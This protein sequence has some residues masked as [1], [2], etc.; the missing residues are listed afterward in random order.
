VSASLLG[1]VAGA[2]LTGHR[3]SQAAVRGAAAGAAFLGAAEAVSRARQRPG[4]IPELWSRILASGALAAPVGWAGGRLSRAR[5]LTV[6][7]VSGAVAGA[8]GLRPQK[9][10]LG[11]A[12]GAA[13]GGAFELRDRAAEPAVV[14]AT[15]VVA[16][17][18]L[19]A[20]LFRDPQV[21]MLAERVHAEDLPFVV[22]LESRSWYVGT[23]YVRQL[24][25]VLGGT[26]TADAADVGIVAALESLAGPEFDPAQ[27]DPL[28]REFYEHT[29]RFL[30]DI[31]PEWRLWVRPGYLLYRNLFAR[32]LGQA[33]VPMNQRETQRGIRS[34]IDTIT[35]PGED[36]VTVRG[37]IRSFTDNDEPIYIGIY[38]TYR[39]EE[40]GY[41]SVGF[42]LPQASFTATLAPM[43]RPGGGLILTSRSELKH[44]GHYLTYI[45][46][47]TRELTTA[48]VLGFA[49]QLDVYVENGELRAKHAFWVFGFPFMVLHYRMHRKNR[50]DNQVP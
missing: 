47:E 19:S 41:V 1:A 6:G 20:L 24:A 25:D 45:D 8:L 33:S 13:V 42:P 16:F 18:V 28:V 29:T 4:Q 37:W 38:T 10:V 5:P 2:A 46:P 27:V 14:A 15:S 35:A 12:V 36:V 22:P 40:R 7:V 34:R 32:P 48:A 3:A 39:D 31:V 26:Y 17:R 11:P 43:A 49:E 9:V 30:L 21:S 50:A 23:A 44:P